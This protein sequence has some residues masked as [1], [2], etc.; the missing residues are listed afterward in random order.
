MQKSRHL[1]DARKGLCKLFRGV[2]EIALPGLK[3]PAEIGH[4]DCGN[5]GLNALIAVGA[6]ASVKGLLLIVVSEQAK[7]HRHIAF[8]IEVLDALGNAF[9]NEF[10]MHRFALDHATYG[11]DGIVSV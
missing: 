10:E 3:P 6:A 1:A 8:G 11:N 7:D 5:R 2:L 4:L 9:A